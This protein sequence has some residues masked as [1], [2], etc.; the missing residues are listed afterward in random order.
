MDGVICPVLVHSDDGDWMG[1]Y[2]AVT[3]ALLYQGHD[4]EPSRLLQILG[5]THTD[6]YGVRILG[7]HLPRTLD[8]LIRDQRIPDEDGAP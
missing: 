7:S 2:D 6:M 1:V 5:V 3:H 4:I 8:E